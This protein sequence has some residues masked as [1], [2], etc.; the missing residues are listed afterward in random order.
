[1]LAS[2]TGLLVAAA[3]AVVALSNVILATPASAQD[4]IRKRGNIAC[5]GDG[6]RLCKHAFQGGDMAVLQCFQANKTKLSGTCRKFLTEI[7]QLY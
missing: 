2:R 6:P 7:G 1:M 4:D 5:K 3:L